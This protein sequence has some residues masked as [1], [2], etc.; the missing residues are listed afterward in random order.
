MSKSH[1]KTIVVDEE[2]YMALRR[3]QKTLQKHVPIKD[4]AAQAIDAHIAG[5]EKVTGEKTLSIMLNENK[6]AKTIIQEL[7]HTLPSITACSILVQICKERNIKAEDI[8]PKTIT[9]ELIQSICRHI[10]LINRAGAEVTEEVL[11]Y[12][13]ELERSRSTYRNKRL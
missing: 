4:I 8:S 7:E 12:I 9:P 3:Y 5:H 2:R 6:F 1:K 13:L 11:T 10:R